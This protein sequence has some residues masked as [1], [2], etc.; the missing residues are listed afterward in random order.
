MV[1]GTTAEEEEDDDDENDDDDDTTVDMKE[2]EEGT[3]LLLLLLLPL[4]RE[5]GENLATDKGCVELVEIEEREEVILEEE[6]S[7]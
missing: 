6:D 3:V 2:E 1:D 4:E 5:K 7:Q